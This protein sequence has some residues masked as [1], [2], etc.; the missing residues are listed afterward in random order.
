MAK[1]TASKKGSGGSVAPKTAIKRRRRSG[2]ALERRWQCDKPECAKRYVRVSCRDSV[3]GANG[4]SFRIKSHG[5]HVGDVKA[6]FLA[7]PRAS[8]EIFR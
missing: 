4:W 7:F 1:M 3:H 5:G 8:L 2:A 6:G